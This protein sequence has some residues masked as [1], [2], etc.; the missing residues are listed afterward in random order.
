MIDKYINKKKSVIVRQVM[1]H[2]NSNMINKKCILFY[3][4]MR[5]DRDENMQ[6]K[7]RTN[8]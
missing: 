8:Y 3:I 6:S 1:Q 7:A 4:T 2:R 5:F